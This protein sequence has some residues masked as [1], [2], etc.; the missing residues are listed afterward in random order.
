MLQDL[1]VKT[2]KLSLQADAQP[3]SQLE[4]FHVHLGYPVLYFKCQ[5]QLDLPVLLVQ[6]RDDVAVDAH[7][8]VDEEEGAVRDR[9]PALDQVHSVCP[10][11]GNT[12][13]TARSSIP[14]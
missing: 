6:L 9:G 8:A 11:I 7:E 10:E 3:S 2:Q 1:K 12:C 14:L 13:F 5:I 4:V